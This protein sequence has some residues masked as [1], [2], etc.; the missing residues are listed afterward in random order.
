MGTTF[1]NQKKNSF[2]VR[3]GTEVNVR[4]QPA[5][6]SQRPDHMEPGKAKG[7]RK[8]LENQC[9]KIGGENE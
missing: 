9:E 1:L 3:R 7:K 8:T 6:S 4:D 5:A 2:F